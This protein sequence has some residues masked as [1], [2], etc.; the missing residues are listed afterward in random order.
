[1]EQLALFSF[2]EPPPPIEIPHDIGEKPDLTSY[3]YYIVAFS[4]GKDSCSSLLH[5]LESGV[6]RSR[7]GLFHHDVDG[8][9]PFFD[10][11]ITTSYCEAVAKA[12][13]VP[14]YM[15]WR[16]GGLL[17]EMLRN[18]TPTAPVIFEK[19]DGTLG[20]AGG[21]GPIGTRLR[22][23]QVTAN[24]QT[25]YCSAATKIDV[26]A[27]ALR[28]QDRF[29]GKR[30][31]FITGERAQESAARS[32]YQSLERHR[33]DTRDG[34]RRVRHIDHWRPILQWSE[35]EVWAIMQRHGLNPHP[36]YWLGLS[37]ASCAFCIFG[38]ADQWAT[39]KHI[40]P[41]RFEI[42]AGYEEQFGVTIKRN[43]SVRELAA[44]GKPYPSALASPE[45][46]RLALSETYNVP[47]LVDPQSWMHPPGAFGEGGGPT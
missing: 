45:I 39:L 16:E 27:A 17:R 33:S 20:K 7:I 5:L 13:G 42:V 28:R 29:L 26:G 35:Q 14:I 31:L 25:R 19:P 41:E 44:K 24:L 12:F 43:M 40:W 47:V 2:P 38:G 8:R 15:S 22:Y 37:R 23:P 34:T 9:N 11:P 10:W 6:D 1:V 21:D 32:R 18:G 4:G 3:D 30:T 36:C 46:A